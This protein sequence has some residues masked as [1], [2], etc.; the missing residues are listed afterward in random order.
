[1]SQV[2]DLRQKVW[3][4]I[5]HLPPDELERMYRLI[6]LVKDEFIDM[7]SEERYL[8]PGWRQAEQEASEAYQRGG[9]RAYDS[10]DAIMDDILADSAE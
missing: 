10:V 6:L 8:T 2:A 1:M 4:E 3:A 5:E 7:T 9:L